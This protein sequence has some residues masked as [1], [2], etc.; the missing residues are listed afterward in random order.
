LVKPFRDK[1]LFIMLDIARHRYGIERGFIK[2]ETQ[3]ELTSEVTGLIGKSSFMKELTI[4][5]KL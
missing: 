1:D 3:V 2:T 5:F 4:K